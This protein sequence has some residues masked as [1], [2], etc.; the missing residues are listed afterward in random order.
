[1]ENNSQNKIQEIQGTVVKGIGGFYYVDTEIGVITTRG[2]GNIR[3]D[4]NILYVGDEVIITLLENGEG[5][6]EKILPRKNCFV[7]PPIANIDMLVVVVSAQKPKANPYLLD[8]FLCVCQEKNIECIICVNKT[9]SSKGWEAYESLLKIYGGVY[10]II[11]ISGMT[12]EGFSTLRALLENKIVALAGPSGVGKSTILNVMT[13]TESME[14]GTISEKNQRGKHTTRHVEILKLNNTTKILDT[15]GF[16]SID[17]PSMDDSEVREMF[18]EIFKIGKK[19][20]FQD[21][22]HLNEPEC[23]VRAAVERG[24][25]SKSRYESYI[26]FLQE[27]RDKNIF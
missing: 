6:I 26:S 19:C 14:V 20:K 1:M 18:P 16:T 10:R 8:R 11:P 12:G 4:G 7:R 13:G 23:M 24:E 2:R 5:V 17:L 21:C 3:K 9:E 25:I 27:V 15:P 22:F